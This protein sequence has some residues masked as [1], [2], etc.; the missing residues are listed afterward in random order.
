MSRLTALLTLV[1]GLL[2]TALA[3]VAAEGINGRFPDG[4]STIVVGNGL[5][6]P[7]GGLGTGPPNATGYTASGPSSGITGTPSTVFTV[8]ATP[9]GGVF[10]GAQTI[11]ISDGGGGT[12]TPSVGSP[13]T[14]SITVTPPAGFG[15][16]TFTYT[17]A[18]NGA[19]T[20]T[21]TNGQAWANAGPL[22]YTTTAG[23]VQGS[24]KF[25]G[26]CTTV[27]MVNGVLSP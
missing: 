6:K 3:Q 27:W 18:S 13:G 19:H 20:L 25:N 26:N 5:S 2:L 16:F 24:L 9:V 23:C 11:T 12:F 17:A 7:A 22:T 21:F 1:A 10:S 14:S 4:I 8:T 15:S